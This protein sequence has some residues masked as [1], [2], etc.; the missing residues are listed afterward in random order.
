MPRTIPKLP[1]ALPNSLSV[2]PKQDVGADDWVRLVE[3]LNLGLSTGH[4]TVVVSQEPG[5]TVSLSGASYTT[6]FVWRIPLLS[7]Q[8]VGVRCSVY[9]D[10]PS[11][12][13][14]ARWTSTYGGGSTVVALG[15]AA[16]WY[17]TAA[18]LPVAADPTGEF[19]EITL[20][21]K[22]DVNLGNLYVAYERLDTTG[23]WPGADG[24]LPNFFTAD[25]HAL[26]TVD[27][28]QD[29]CLSSAHAATSYI[30]VIEHLSSRVRSYFNVSALEGSVM[31]DALASCPHRAVIPVT[32]EQDLVCWVRYKNTKTAAS[33]ILVQCGGGD[34]DTLNAWGTWPT[35]TPGA[36]WPPNSGFT[37]VIDVPASTPP[38]WARITLPAYTTDYVGVPSSYPGFLHL[39]VTD[40]SV[41]RG[42]G[43]VLGAQ[44]MSMSVWGK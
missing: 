44:V 31:P 43:A 26:D 4:A 40:G 13:A 21:T 36:D 30:P 39:A 24:A 16:G 15:A 29:G 1:V 41:G 28:T 33:K 6:R 2:L 7:A 37:R 32:T 11:A 5:D 25:Y 19:E 35:M 22:A 12:T 17:D 23:L 38:T 18:L 42:L 3:A 34:T 20:E 8:H 27:V 9:G 10:S 14:T